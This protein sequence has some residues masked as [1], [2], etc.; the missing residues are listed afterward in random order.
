MNYVEKGH[1]TP[2]V[3]MHGFPLDS[4][5]WESQADDLSDRY[6]VITPDLRG[7]GHSVSSSAF[8]MDS[9]AEDV[10]QLLARI[11]AL[12]CILGGLSMGGYVALAFARR[13]PNDLLAL[14][15][16][17]TRAEADAPAGRE[18]RN[19]MIESVKTG[20]SK[21]IAD[22]MFPKMMGEQTVKHRQDIAHR[23]RHIMESQSPTTIAHALAALRDRED[24]MGNL[25]SIAVPTLILVGKEDAITPP[26]MSEAMSKLLPH[27]QLVVLPNS[28]HMSPMEQPDEVTRA[29]RRFA[30]TLGK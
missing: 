2:L 18:A 20:G 16:V 28:G 10:H 7:F 21:V 22:Q 15:L 25:A 29:I 24:H 1:G 4:R 3:L 14:A 26:S 9:L 12:P 19:T 13:F 17:D 23:L 11:G 30:E 8:T 27:P 5:V 6:R